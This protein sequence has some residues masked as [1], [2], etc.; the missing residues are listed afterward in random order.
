MKKHITPVL[1]AL[2]LTAIGMGILLRN[3]PNG[4]APEPTAS[5]EQWTKDVV[6]SKSDA[7]AKDTPTPSPSTATTA[8]A[9]T[10]QTVSPVVQEVRKGDVLVAAD[11]A[12]YPIREYKSFATNDTYGT[13]W[14]TDKINLPAAQAIGHGALQTIIA[15]IDGG[16]SLEHEEFSGRILDNNGE[17]GLSMSEQPSD[18]NCTDRGL[19]LDRACNNI[20]DN[21]D[22]V[23]DNETGTTTQQNRSILNCTDRALSLDRSCNLTDDD[24]NGLVDDTNGFDFISYESSVT[25]GEVNPSGSGATH[26]TM[27][28][29]VAAANNNN[30]RGLAGVNGQAKILP[31][32]ALSDDG[33][34]DTISVSRAIRYAADRGAHVINLSLGSSSSDTYLRQ[35]VQ[36]AISKGSVVVAASG[37]DGCDCV[38]YPARYE[39]VFAVGASNQSDVP[40]SFSSYGSSLDVLAPGISMI[41]STWTSTNATTAYAGGLAGTSFSAPV[42]SGLLAWARSHQPNASAHQ[43]LATVSE[44]TS[45]LT[46]AAGESRNNTLGFGRVDA[47]A[48]VTRTVTPQTPLQRNMFYPVSGGSALAALEPLVPFQVY[49]CENRLGTTPLYRLSK[50]NSTVYTVSPYEKQ[51]G[52]EQGYGVTQIGFYCMSLPT[53]TPTILRSINIGAESANSSFK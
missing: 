28:A 38:S 14:W 26:G 37:N 29:G 39:E 52:I 25:P 3:R 53:D 7:G 9:D 46:L 24:A 36:Y 19:P 45:R 51:R 2:V 49:G 18:R 50:I 30:N 41:S 15:V 1:I 11:G 34:G 23:L 4:I 5:N 22:G 6:T 21:G 13:Q 12:E 42:V 40:T 20:D 17:K 10:P 32:Q 8:Q 35:A 31:V 44:Q 43:L 48:A 47:A 33:V 27:V 16:T